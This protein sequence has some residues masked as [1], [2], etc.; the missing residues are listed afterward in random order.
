VPGV[1]GRLAATDLRPREL[2]LEAGFGE[3]G[4]GIRDGV[5]ED[6]VA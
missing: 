5:R 6:Q 2:D 4:P 3:E 1:E